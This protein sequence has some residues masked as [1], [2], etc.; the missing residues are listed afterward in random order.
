[1]NNSRLINSE[2]RWYAW[3]LGTHQKG[4][5]EMLRLSAWGDEFLGVNLYD[6]QF[7]KERKTS[8]PT[9][10]CSSSSAKKQSCFVVSKFAACLL[11]R[12]Q[13]SFPPRRSA[14]PVITSNCPNCQLSLGKMFLFLST[15]LHCCS[16][17]DLLWC[18][19]NNNDKVSNNIYLQ[20]FCAMHLTSTQHCKFSWVLQTGWK[21][22]RTN[23]N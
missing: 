3:S 6:Y 14:R 17:Y 23:N 22:R 11:I 1:M 19:N 12:Y 10:Q 16:S 5:W 18:K 21:Q 8:I 4:L 13:G 2:I 20:L 9:A 15:P 7:I